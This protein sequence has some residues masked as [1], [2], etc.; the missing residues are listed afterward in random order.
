[1]LPNLPVRIPHATCAIEPNPGTL[2]RRA[3]QAATRHEVRAT[4]ARARPTRKRKDFYPGKF[5]ELWRAFN[6]WFQ[7]ITQPPTP[8]RRFDEAY[9]ITAAGQDRTLSAAFTNLLQSSPRFQARA[10]EFY[11]LW[12]VFDHRWLRD[13]RLLFWGQATDAQGRRLSRMDY[14]KMCFQHQ[15]RPNSY[16][17]SCFATQPP[18]AGPQ[19]FVQVPM[20][21]GHTLQAI[22]Q[23][24]CNY[25]HDIKGEIEGAV[26]EDYN[27]LYLSHYL[28]WHVWG[29]TI[30]KISGL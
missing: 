8:P 23:V 21:W 16:R 18:Q 13:Q 26:N 27:F 17:P 9:R 10:G 24:R 2:D 19:H 28:L 4:L 29:K 1:M 11:D 7:A 14:V 6:T 22:Y 3:L 5:F 30:L 12:P 20:D 15:P 25:F